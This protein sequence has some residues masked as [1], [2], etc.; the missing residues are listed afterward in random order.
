MIEKDGIDVLT[1]VGVGPDFSLVRIDASGTKAE[2]FLTE[3]DVIFLGSLFLKKR[4]DIAA[5]HS[6]ALMEEQGVEPVIMFPAAN[7]E[8]N[9]DLHESEV[10]LQI[11]DI[12]QNKHGFSFAPAGARTLADALL[13]W[14]SKVETTQAKNRPQ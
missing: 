5:R 14:A 8:I 11:H 2:L 7:F 1:L 9:S 6:T 13:R 3:S 4:A 12:Y 10:L